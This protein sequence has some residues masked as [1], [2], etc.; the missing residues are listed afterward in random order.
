MDNPAAQGRAGASIKFMLQRKNVLGGPLG[1]CSNA[2]KTGFYR[3]GCCDTGEEDTGQHTVCIVA[4]EEFLA[5]SKSH[6]NDLSTP[7]PQFGFP[8]VKPGDRWC[9]CVLRWK[10]ALEAG[11]APGVVL[12]A[13]HE[14]ALKYVR[15]EDLLTHA[16]SRSVC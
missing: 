16:V 12:E 1:I 7:M 6:G 5:F 15:L 2:P 9:L 4:T 10:E 3:N 13:T 14:E 11:M 8:G